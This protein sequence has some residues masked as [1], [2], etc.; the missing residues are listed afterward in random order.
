MGH[1]S[2]AREAR[3]A[4]RC[5]PEAEQQPGAARLLPDLEAVASVAMMGSPRPAPGLSARGRIPIPSSATETS[6]SSPSIVTVTCTSPGS[7]S[8]ARSR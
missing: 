2:L 1:L 4:G 5:K 3:S 6:S 7:E 8:G